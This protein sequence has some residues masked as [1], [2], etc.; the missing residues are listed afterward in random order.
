MARPRRQFAVAHGAQLPAQGR[1]G[2]A[3]AE[4]FP[5][6]LRQIDQSPANDAVHGRDRAVLD[7]RH[8]GLTLR[9]IQLRWLA[10]SLAVD[11]PIR[12]PGVEPQRPVANGLQ[13]NVANPGGIT[14]SA[15]IVN[16]R[17]RQKPARMPGIPRPPRKPPQIL[18]RE[19]V[20]KRNRRRHRIPQCQSHEG[21]TICVALGIS[22][23]S[24][25]HRD[26]VLAVLTLEIGDQIKR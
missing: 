3:D 9:I 26:L 8:Q 10:G 12:S 11:E 22:R 7:D 13:A 6:P 2:D 4:L 5:N 20:S 25:I 23:M 14:A 1:L 17:Q 16:L 24:Q 21:I 18:S 15:A 19:I